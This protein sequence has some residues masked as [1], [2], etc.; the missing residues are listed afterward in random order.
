M[1]DSKKLAVAENQ[2]RAEQTFHGARVRKDDEERTN[3]G[4]KTVLLTFNI[5]YIFTQ[6][7][8]YGV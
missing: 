2:T 1:K 8:L 5:N 7:F 6:M 3:A 4:Y